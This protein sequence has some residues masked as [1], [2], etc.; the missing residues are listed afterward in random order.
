MK[1]HLIATSFN[2]EELKSQGSS[3][4][5]NQAQKLPDHLI[6]QALPLKRQSYSGSHSGRSALPNI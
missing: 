4:W 5:L 2:F 3:C 1:V 6:I